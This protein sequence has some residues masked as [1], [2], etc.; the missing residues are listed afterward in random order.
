MEK[1]MKTYIK[2]T[3]ALILALLLAACCLSGCGSKGDNSVPD[4]QAAV[5][6]AITPCRSP[7][8]LKPAVLRS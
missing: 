5:Q 3:L 7:Q 6:K 2:K 8:T 4:F 1:D